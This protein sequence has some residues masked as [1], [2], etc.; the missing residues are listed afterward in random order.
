MRKLSLGEVN[1]FPQDPISSEWGT[2]IWPQLCLPSEQKLFPFQG[3][4][5]PS[6]WSQGSLDW[7]DG[8]M[9]FNQLFVIVF[10]SVS[11]SRNGRVIQI[12]WFESAL[13]EETIF[14]KG[15]SLRSVPA[16]C[17]VMPDSLRPCGLQPARLLCPWDSPGESAGLGCHFLLQRTFPIQGLELLLLYPLSH[18]LALR[19]SVTLHKTFFSFLIYQIRTILSLDSKY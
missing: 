4:V 5:P 16:V 3:W 2:K 18:Q 7:A 17:S 1:D 9:T 10:D 15:K 13:V 8:Q 19:S 12:E 6:T 14:F 11:F